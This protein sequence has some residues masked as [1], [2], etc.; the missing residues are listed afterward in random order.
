MME[1]ERTLLLFQ[2]KDWDD[3]FSKFWL[4]SSCSHQVDDMLSAII[5]CS[6]WTRF[7]MAGK[8]D[9]LCRKIGLYELRGVL[10][11]LCNLVCLKSLN[12]RQSRWLWVQ[13]SPDGELE[14]RELPPLTRATPV[15]CCWGGQGMPSEHYLPMFLGQSQSMATSR[16]A[17]AV[18]GIHTNN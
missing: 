16:F 17:Y 12:P 18:K 9:N 15:K 13:Y 10:S 11:S 5:F 3:A 4:E 7:S 2:S 1:V 6:P 14:K 8:N